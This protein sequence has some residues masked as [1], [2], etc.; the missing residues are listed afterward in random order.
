MTAPDARDK[1]LDAQA[2]LLGSLLIDERC[3]G[4][5][6]Q[7]VTAQ[8]FTA[9]AYRTVFCAIQAIF[10]E[11]GHVDPVT[12]M[13]R[14]P[15][16][17]QD[18]LMQLMEITP[19][20]A[21]YRD[22]IAIL[23]REARMYR[24]REI[25]TR[26]LDAEDEAAARACM[27]EANALLVQRADVRHMDTAALY[28][29]YFGRHSQTPDYI[30]WGIP[31]LDKTVKA[32]HGD[33]VILGGYP[34]AGKTALALSF[35]QYIGQSAR[36]GFFSYETDIER[37]YDRMVA[38]VTGIGMPRQLDNALTDADW[39]T[40]ANAADALTRPKLELIEASGMTVADIRSYALARHYDVIFV[41][42]LQK[43]RSNRSVRATEYEQVTQVSNDLQLFGR[44]TGVTVVA[45][46]QLARQEAT[47]AGELKAPTMAS[48][49]SSGQIEQDASVVL[50]LWREDGKP[51][52]DN[53]NRVLAIAK[54]K[55]GIAGRQMILGFDGPTM[56]FWDRMGGSAPPPLPVTVSLPE[57]AGAEQLDF[58]DPF[59][60]EGKNG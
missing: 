4:P 16:L 9:A 50:L 35:A 40:M 15:G 45:L 26:I 7:E 39:T 33:M 60:E 53:T 23:K 31:R 41:D 46:A 48:L 22:Y 10:G 42:Y 57:A 59:V 36:V 55:D 30:A 43:I 8:D 54:N 13:A 3:I 37:L 19:T 29:D 32:R 6:L 24:L 28:Q 25:A 17:Q 56:R 12:V 47:A 1:L 21:H 2:A 49:R 51:N 44:Q 14:I 11:R 20:A 34:S 18:F 5:T 38:Q 27:D 52:S 58:V